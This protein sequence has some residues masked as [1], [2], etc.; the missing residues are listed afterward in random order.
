MLTCVHDISHNVP[1]LHIGPYG[2][3]YL[4]VHYLVFPGWTVHKLPTTVQSRRRSGDE[5]VQVLQTHW[6]RNLG[7]FFSE[8]IKSVNCC[9]ANVT[10]Q[11]RQL[12]RV[13]S[14][15]EQHG[16]AVVNTVATQQEG[17]GFEGLKL[18]FCVEFA[19]FL[20]VFSFYCPC[21][22]VYG[23]SAVH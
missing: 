3:V 18:F 12:I 4:Q 7:R 15:R 22:P 6:K 2:A 19:C 13:T 8:M 17:S 20:S 21:F 23:A 11:S 10:E 5:Y 9:R 1:L 16:G 14:Y